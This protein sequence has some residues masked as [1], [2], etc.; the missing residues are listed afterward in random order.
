MSSA[1]KS[2]IDAFLQLLYPDDAAC[3]L[4]GRQAHVNAHWLCNACSQTVRMYDS[5]LFFPAGL[6]ALDG[7]TAGFFYDAPL[8][9]AMHRFKYDGA[10]Y[11][12]RCFMHNVHILQ[13]WDIDVA[14]PV[15]LHPRRER[16]RG[17]NQSL[18]LAKALGLPVGAGLLAR[19][20][21]TKTQTTLSREAREQN[22]HQAFK[23]SVEVE[24]MRVL[25]IDD[26][27]TTGSTLNAAACALREAG[28]KCVYAA[29]AV[30]AAPHI[31]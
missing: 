16:A 11:L 17:Y 22:L 31:D 15:P 9:L 10:L 24:G 21:D 12:A 1:K 20:I 19:I 29:V 2:R 25:L 4:C 14:V 30:I 5:R 26:V 6:T 7:L 13:A 8:H 27:L 18:Y 3:F 28:A 23:A